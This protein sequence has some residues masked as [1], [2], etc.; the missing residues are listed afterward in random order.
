MPSLRTNLEKLAVEQNPNTMRQKSGSPEIE[1]VLELPPLPAPVKDF[2]SYFSQAKDTLVPELL[3]PYHAYE[4]ELR[5]FYA[6]QPDDPVLKDGHINTVPIYAGQESALKVRARKLDDETEAE[7]EKYIMGLSKADR[8]PDGSP[9]VVTSLKEFQSNFNLFSE[10]SLSELDWSNVVAAGSSVTTALLPVP[11]KWS[12]SKKSLREYYHDR[13]A[14]ASDVDLFLYGLTEEEG[15]QK[16]KRIETTVKDSILHEVTTIRTKNAITIASQYPTRHVQIVLRLYDSISQII[17]G[18]DVDCA[19]VAYDGKEVYGSPRALAAFST[20]TNTIDLTRRSPSY[21]NRLSKYS[22]RGFE[23]HWPDLDRSRVDPTIF[24]RAF[25][26]T[27]GLSRL[28]VLEKL[29]RTVDREGYTD[30]RRKERGRPAVDRHVRDQHK[31]FGNIK[32]EQEDEVADWAEEDQVSNYHTIGVPYGKRFTARKIERVLYTKDLL[33]NSE[34]NRPKEREVELHRHP[35]FFGTAEDVLGDCCGFCPVPKTDEEIEIAEEESKTYITGPLIFV[36]DD[37]GRQ[38]IGSFNPITTDDWTEMA[39]VGNTQ[40]LCQAIVDGDIDYITGWCEQEGN[41]INTRDY[42]G[43][44]PLHLAVINGNADIVKV[45]IDNGA[46]IIARLLDGRCALHIAAQLGHADIIKILMDKSLANEEEEAEKEDKLRAAKLAAKKSGDDD[47]EMED[48]DGSDSEGSGMEVETENDSDN[49]SETQGFTKVKGAALGE[50][51]DILDDEDAPDF[52]DINVVAWDLQCTA[53]HFA[54]MGGHIPVIRM[55]VGEYGAD[56]LLPIKIGTKHVSNQAILSTVLATA[57]KNEKARDV[58]DT[59]L[60]LG[61]TSAQADMDHYTALHYVV[62]RNR[63]DLLDIFYERDGPAVKSVLDLVTM[64]DYKSARTMVSMA[65]K[66]GGDELLKKLLSLGAKPGISFEGFIKCYFAKNEYAKNSTAEQNMK[67]YKTMCSQ[68]IVLAAICEFPK[69]VA[70]LLAHG[71]DP[72]TVTIAGQTALAATYNYNT[73]TAATVLDV[74]QRKIKS[75]K[76][77]KRLTWA[78]NKVPTT[79]HEE[80]YYLKDLKPGTYKYWTAL[81]RY[82]N[83]KTE[84]DAQWVSYNKSLEVESGFEAAVD[85]KM[86]A[87]QSLLAQYE[88]LEEILIEAGAKTFKQAHSHVNLVDIGDRQPKLDPVFSPDVNA[89][90]TIFLFSVPALSDHL[91]EGHFRLF[92]AV[93]SNDIDE[94]KSLTLRPWKSEDGQEHPAL[95]IAVKDTVP[96]RSQHY[97]VSMPGF[98][99][100]S[101]FIVTQK[102]FTGVSPFS[103]AILRGPSHYRM[104]KVIVEIALAQYEP[105]D[106]EGGKIKWSIDYDQAGC[107][108]DHGSESEDSDDDDHSQIGLRSELVDEVFTIDNVAALSTVIK[109]HVKPMDMLHW[110]CN[111]LW[112]I[113]EKER[114][115]EDV[116]GRQSSLVQYAIFTNDTRLLRFLY[117]IAEEHAV[118]FPNEPLSPIVAQYDFEQAIRLGRTEILGEMIKRTGVGIPLDHLVESSGVKLPEEK[119]QYYQGLNVGGKKNASWAQAGNPNGG[120]YIYRVRETTPP[121]LKAAKFGNLASVQWFLSDLPTIKYLEFAA[122]HE[123]DKRVVALSKSENGFKGTA[124]KWLSMRHELLLHVAVMTMPSEDDLP[125]HMELVKYIACNDATFLESRSLGSFTPLHLACTRRSKG[126]IEVLLAL[127]SKVRSRDATGRNMIHH[128]ICPAERNPT[129]TEE[130][131]KRNSLASFFSL[132]G[133]SDVTEMLLERDIL[134]FTPFALWQSQCNANSRGESS[135]ACTIPETVSSYTEGQHLTIMNSVGDLPLHVA[136]KQGRPLHVREFLL[137]NPQTLGRENAT[138][139]TA[140]ELAQHKLQSATVEGLKSSAKS[141]A[142]GWRSKEIFNEGLETKDW[143]EFVPKEVASEDPKERMKAKL[144]KGDM[145]DLQ[146]QR[147]VWEECLEAAERVEV[148]GGELKRRLVSL[149]EANEV[150]R[151]MV[152]AQTKA[153]AARIQQHYLSGNAG[154]EEAGKVEWDEVVA[155]MVHRGG[156]GWVLRGRTVV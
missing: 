63:P 19:C 75:L 134:G 102:G 135:H 132:F 127:G 154:E 126:V 49:D 119:P 153:S 25:R 1:A 87:I 72:N 109:S 112:F 12:G 28:L 120:S 11:E 34:W 95:Q 142:S 124:T 2:A 99:Y 110:P 13:L 129:W 107:C 42:V 89:Y 96:E 141:R 16:I 85:A 31:L 81:N 68:P 17:T 78:A 30:E 61:A 76:E 80:A 9:A 41:D 115:K 121:L 98:A 27:L 20:Q 138:G 152:V 101:N 23:V 144:L 125:E 146:A 108:S 32:D 47:E 8:K 140:L 128:L 104:A 71:A 114:P 149:G 15:L 51:N 56:V 136:I 44:A 4:A 150:A 3:E 92:E 82:R 106:N 43:R 38:E 139:I 39:Y 18:F 48:A 46:K 6:Q 65:I 148:D 67:T 52:Y 53:L 113:D 22:H 94:V 36:K 62:E 122:M 40:M 60:Q 57:L 103:L 143:R 88:E 26:K 130:W 77:H 33:L 118:H 70:A 105:R 84:N 54:I 24:E 91:M 21:E 45:L 116:L 117:Q 97:G 151:R 7:K 83:V 69:M 133:K 14:P 59:L 145:Q 66:E 73:I 64:D 37:P 147:W 74:V 58:I 131:E 29:P 86:S 137:Q 5:K 90:E 55:L 79:L 35:C 111:A 100:R 93:W 50:S 123:N 156:Q 10:S 155:A